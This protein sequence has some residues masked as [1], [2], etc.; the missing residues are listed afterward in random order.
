MPNLLNNAIT[1]PIASFIG[2]ILFPFGVSFLLPIFTIILVKEKEDRIL[3]MMQMN[4]LKKRAYFISHFLHFYAMHFVSSTVFLVTGKVTNLEM[5][6]KTSAG[7]LIL[8]FFMW[9]NVQIALAFL[10]S[11]I[12]SKNRTALGTLFIL[13]YDESYCVLGCACW[14]CGCYRVGIFVWRYSCAVRI[15][16]LAAFCILSNLESDELLCLYEEFDTVYY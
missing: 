3:I 1:F 5:F 12:F 2:R 7:V 6:S 15:F 9:G 10:F 14:G 4:G 13:F 11:T 16:P 8:M